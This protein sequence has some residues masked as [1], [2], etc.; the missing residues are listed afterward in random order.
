[1]TGS[2]RCDVETLEAAL[3]ASQARVSA[4]EA[5]I[6]SLK[7]MIEKLRRRALYGQR[8]ERKER[9]NRQ[10][11]RYAREG[12]ALRTSTLA[13]QVGACAVTEAVRDAGTRRLIGFDAVKHLLLARIE[14]RPAHL[15]LTRYPHLPQPFV[16]A[17]RA[18]DYAAL[19]AAGVG[20]G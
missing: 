6:T 18:V 15:D 20:R 1:M 12:V 16:A 4:A 13:D 7:L 17:T 2:A 9:L 11:E 3:A 8:S 10:S 5:Q 14:K 19:L